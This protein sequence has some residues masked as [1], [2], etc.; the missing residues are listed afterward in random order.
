LKPYSTRC[1]M[2]NHLS[3]PRQQHLLNFHQPIF[4]M[5]SWCMFWFTSS[6]LAPVLVFSR[7]ILMASQVEAKATCMVL[8]LIMGN[9]QTHTKSTLLYTFLFN[10]CGKMKVGAR[11][12][13]IHFIYLF[14]AHFLYFCFLSFRIKTYMT[15]TTMDL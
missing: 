3:F 6:I 14:I 9:I 13:S 7:T 15:L 1:M 2:L 5:T 8:V 11:G 12:I 10:M 4:E